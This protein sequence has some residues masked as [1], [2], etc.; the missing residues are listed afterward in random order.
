MI[1]SHF[2]PT[3]SK[4]AYQKKQNQVSGNGYTQISTI[5]NNKNLQILQIIAIWRPTIRHLDRP[6]ATF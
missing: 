2:S 3:N 1:F 6:A 5:N 4:Y